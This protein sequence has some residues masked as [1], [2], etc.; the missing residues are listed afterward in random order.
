MSM[1]NGNGNAFTVYIYANEFEYLKWLVLQKSFL[2]TGGDLFGVWQSESCVVVQ[3]VLGP[4][5]KCRRTTTS[6]F[7]DIDYLG[8]VGHYLTSN[9]GI[10]NIG[11]W[12]SHHRLGLAYPSD[13]DQ[14]TVWEHMP[15]VSGGRFL[16]FIANI[17]SFGDAKVG[18]FM[19]NTSTRKMT[20]G[21]FEFL[22]N[23]SP[24][25]HTFARKEQFKHEAEPRQNWETFFA[26]KLRKVQRG[27]GNKV[28][29]GD[30]ESLTTGDFCVCD[31]KDR[32]HE[33]CCEGCQCCDCLPCCDCDCATSICGCFRATFS[34]F[35]RIVANLGRT[36]IGCLTSLYRKIRP[37][38][39]RTSYED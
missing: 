10:C 14:R 11:E 5:A 4:G 22:M 9:E 20:Q 15:T 3:L 30:L 24:I 32:H 33:S 21:K 38:G 39:R 31:V 36:L 23:C 25:R 8:N 29:D 7:Q 28:G 18:C 1:S 27:R 16:V 2:E 34:I 19:F 13:G 17:E 12:H 37:D 35:C 6:F 26:S